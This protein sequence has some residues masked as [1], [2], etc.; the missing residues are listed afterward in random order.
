MLRA[1]SPHPPSSAS[2]NEPAYDM[3]SNSELSNPMLY[4]Q[5]RQKLDV[6]NRLHS[7]GCVPF[8]RFFHTGAP[9]LTGAPD[10]LA[11]RH[12]PTADRGHRQPER[13]QVIAHRG[14][15][16]H[17]APSRG[18]YMH[19]VRRSPRVYHVCSLPS[20]AAARLSVVSPARKP[21]GNAPS[22]FD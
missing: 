13:G 22:P 15:L 10:K 4:S 8:S 9:F 1:L 5:M 19:A 6:M 18:G 12:R 16:W 2:P 7:A 20:R 21:L 17:H 11:A 3:A 14:H